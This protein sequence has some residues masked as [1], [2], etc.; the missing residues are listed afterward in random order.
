MNGGSMKYVV[1]SQKHLKNILLVEVLILLAIKFN[2]K[3]KCNH[4]FER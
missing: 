1:I 3:Y 4:E 2:K